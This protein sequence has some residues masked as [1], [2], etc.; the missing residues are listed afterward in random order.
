[1]LYPIQ[2]DLRE[3]NDG[4]KILKDTEIDTL[5]KREAF[6]LTK[7]DELKGDITYE[8]AL[9]EHERKKRNRE[10]RQAEK[11]ERRARKTKDEL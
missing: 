7:I 3:H 4:Y 10:K 11:E 5:K 2:R 8:I 6:Y 9:A 1:M